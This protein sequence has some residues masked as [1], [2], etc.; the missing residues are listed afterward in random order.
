[1][2]QILQPIPVQ[3]RREVTDVLF[4]TPTPRKRY[5]QRIRKEQ[6]QHTEQ[7]RPYCFPCAKRNYEEEQKRKHQNEANPKNLY[8]EQ[9]QIGDF[10]TDTYGQAAYIDKTGE[11]DI[12]EETIIDGLKVDIIRKKYLVY[13]CKPK[14][15]KISVETPIENKKK[16]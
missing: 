6:V 9:I 2:S 10:P 3:Q 1:M 7:H 16:K 12:K 14:G 4:N 8:E 11:Q 5:L 13:K 15:H